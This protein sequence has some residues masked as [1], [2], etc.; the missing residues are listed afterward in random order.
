M[1]DNSSHLFRTV[2]VGRA[3]EDIVHQIKNNIFEG[4]LGPGDRLPS[5]K[6]LIEQF[7]V[8]RITVRDAMRV[9]E[10]QGLVEIKV[11]AGGGAFV[12]TPGSGPITQVLTDMLRLHGISTSE[13][14]EARLVIETSIVTFAAERATPEDIECMR[15]AIAEAR[16]SRAAG[17]PRFT[18]HS[19]NFH[20]ALAKAAR[21]QVLFF[22]VS[23]FRTPFY[24]TLEKLLPD[25]RMADRA[26][27]DHQKLL[28]AITAHDAESG[29]QVM[30]E[31]LAYFQKRTEKLD[32]FR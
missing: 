14:V 21:N 26:I 20:I 31:H 13:L 12:S 3:S 8:S 24:E 32:R 18:P 6:E 27:D 1:A 29:C 16:A 10:S 7:G 4:R 15:K 9:L 2:R 22:T 28:D 5:E 11:G 23:S 25:D 17:E 30:K 19:I